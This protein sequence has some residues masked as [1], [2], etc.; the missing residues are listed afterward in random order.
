MQRKSNGYIGFS[1]KVN[2]SGVLNKTLEG[3]SEMLKLLEDE[4]TTTTYQTT[5]NQTDESFFED[6]YKKLKS[7]LI[8]LAKASHHRTFMETCLN[9]KTPPKNMRLWVEPHIYH[10]SKEVEREWRETLTTASLKLLASLIKHY[11]KIIDEEKQT[12]E[13]TLK[14]VTTKIK[15]TKNKE[16]RDTQATKWKELRQTAQDEA[17]KI[18]DDLKETRHKKLTQRKRKRE[19]SQ[20]DL[21]PQP[22]RSF[23][24][25]L[26]GFMQEYA[27]KKQIPKKRRRPPKRGGKF[28]V[29]RQ[30]PSQRKELRQKDSTSTTKTLKKRKTYR[31]NRNKLLYMHP[32][33]LSVCNNDNNFSIK[34][35]EPNQKL[36]DNR[37]LV[38]LSKQTLSET[39]KDVLRKGLNFIPKPKKLDIHSL[40]KDVR[41]FMHRMKCKY[42]FYH[43]PQ[44]TRNR[45]PF[46]I[47]KQTYPN[48]ERLSDNGTLDTFLHRIRLEIVNENKHKQSKTDNLTRQE[49]KALND[50][51]NN[52]TLIINKAD[53][54]STVVVQD[55]SDYIAEAMKHLA[56][57]NT[58]IKLQE[59]IT[60]KLKEVITAKLEILY[61]N[62][63]LLINWYQFCKPPPNHRTSK[64]YFFKKI[65]KNPMG[66][67]PIVSSCD[68]MGTNELSIEK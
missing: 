21:I 30:G 40:H 54:G 67:R 27:T 57:P 48:P 45:D 33:S 15:H 39:Q 47:K 18:G 6:K 62:G 24:E 11:T 2:L 66:I 13:G 44:Q 31:K 61:K 4:E 23:V 35:P 1:W 59:N 34:Q 7:S 16:E 42:E 3:T 50:L 43:K 55:R 12:L 25:A 20:E 17:K 58:Y 29:Q 53:K 68:S 60:H 38:I 41:L 46:R 9:A 8:V 14:D 10:S 37:E 26:T 49:R 64:L 36:S 56:D 63:F 51:I 32:Y 22:K 19:R 28:F 52:P 65:H 5:I